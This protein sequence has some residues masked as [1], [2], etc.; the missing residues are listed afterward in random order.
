MPCARFASANT[1]VALLLLVATARGADWPQWQGPNRDLSNSES[2]LRQEWPEGGPPRLW[3]YRDAGLGYGGP[4]IADGRLFML[5]SRDGNAMLI[6]LDAA[7]GEEQWTTKLGPEFTNRWGN[8]PRST[9]TVDGGVVYALAAKGALACVSASSGS[10]LWKIKMQDLGGE[11]PVWGYSE[12]PLV[13]GDRLLVTPGGAKGAIAALDKQTGKPL[14]QSTDLT[15]R[16]HYSSIISAEINGQP[17]YVQ[18]LSTA[19]VGVSKADGAVLWQAPW[20][21]PTAAIPTPVV[22][23]NRVYATSGYGVGCLCVEIGAGNEVTELY[24][25]KTMKNKHGGI[26]L[27]DG[28]LYGHS[29]GVGWVCQDFATGKRVWR[30]RRALGMGALGYAD[31]MLYLLD[32]ESGDVALVRATPDGW[33][34][35][36]RFTLDPQTELRKPSG[37]IWVHPVIA[38]GKLY[39][40]DQE[41]LHCYDVTA[42]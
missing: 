6:C 27:L 42:E 41:I 12:S 20:P 36:G 11:V 4:A 18:L 25:N 31:G 29:D 1:A 38:G 26:V 2:G 32:K 40:R 28:Y 7:S 33:D 30:E 19:L 16:A 10:V 39:L 13:D 37:K 9:P 3:L 23:S 5:G 15:P 17:Q 8:G 22:D 21:D 14:W 34:Q 35:Q 24:R